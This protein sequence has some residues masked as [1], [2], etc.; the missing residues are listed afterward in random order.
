MERNIGEHSTKGASASLPL[1]LPERH[2]E[3][4]RP[5]SAEPLDTLHPIPVYSGRD[6]EQPRKQAM[7]L[8]RIYARSCRHFKRWLFWY[9]HLGVI[10]FAILLLLPFEPIASSSNDELLGVEVQISTQ[11]QQISKE[12]EG[13]STS[14]HEL[15]STAHQPMTQATT[16][17]SHRPTVRKPGFLSSIAEL[18][19]RNTDFP[20]YSVKITNPGLSSIV[21]SIVA[22]IPVPLSLAVDVAPTDL[23]L[24]RKDTEPNI[25]P[26]TK[27]SLPSQSLTGDAIIQVENQHTIISDMN[28]FIAFVDEAVCGK[29][30][31]LAAH[32]TTT[33]HVGA[34]EL[35]LTLSK[36]VELNGMP[37]IILSSAFAI[38]SADT[39]I[40]LNNLNGFEILDPRAILPP[41]SDGTNLVGT[42]MVPNPSVVTLEMVSLTFAFFDDFDSC[43]PFLSLLLRLDSG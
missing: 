24:Y 19:I 27:V 21:V 31:V 8:I 26:Y 2:N 4:K 35:P 9:G 29:T 22:S 1:G 7:F 16:E 28:Q 17:V 5:R 42:V 37:F 30:F 25:I 41:R 32:G 38:V 12:I 34:L 3:V 11:T 14:S 15:S 40:G 6:L 33:A 23:Y 13:T 39:A 43:P 20:V 18:M 10:L 36:S